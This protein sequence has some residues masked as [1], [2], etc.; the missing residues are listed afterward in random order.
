MSITIIRLFIKTYTY[1][2]SKIRIFVNFYV[3]H[4]KL[5]KLKKKNIR[6]VCK[7]FFEYKLRLLNFSN[8]LKQGVR[9]LFKSARYFFI[10]TKHLL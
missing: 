1:L 6:R 9:N 2:L 5:S 3:F 10:D 7:V 4:D 8:T